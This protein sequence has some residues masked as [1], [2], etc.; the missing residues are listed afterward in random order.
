MEGKVV[1]F[2]RHGDTG[3]IGRYI[4]S[5]DIGLSDVG[6]QQVINSGLLLKGA[7]IEKTLC[8]PLLRCRQSYDLLGLGCDCIVNDLLREVN[9]GLWENKSFSEIVATDKELV[10]SWVEAPENFCFPGG[11]SLAHFRKRL[12]QFT[13]ILDDI[14]EK[15]LLIVAHG[16]VIRHLLCL[17]LK[18]DFNK[19]LVF[20]VQ[21]GRFSKV[22]VYPEGGV[23]TGF[24]IGG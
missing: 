23:L 12:E 9:F 6:V 15:K 10:N 21:P 16:G 7:G 2:L 20:D 13:A 4:G 14:S 8:S 3:M 22:N 11:E 17:L 18:L 5:T 19:Y 1:Y 24:N